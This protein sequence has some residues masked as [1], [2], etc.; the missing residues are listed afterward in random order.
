MLIS[1]R[2]GEED[3]LRQSGRPLSVNAGINIH[4]G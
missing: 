3:D 1:A 4:G 2:E